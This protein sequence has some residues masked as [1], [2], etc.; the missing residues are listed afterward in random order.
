[1]LPRWL[2]A[3]AFVP[4][5]TIIPAAHAAT[6][7]DLAVHTA[8]GVPSSLPPGGSATIRLTVANQGGARAGSS[9][10]DL[11]LSSDAKRSRGDVRLARIVTGSVKAHGKRGVTARV[12]LGGAVG[13]GRYVLLACAD[14]TRRVKER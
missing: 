2:Y 5:L 10:T 7:P 14:A 13:A 4:A 1:M 8:A 12:K 11:L 3:A 9:R 6:R